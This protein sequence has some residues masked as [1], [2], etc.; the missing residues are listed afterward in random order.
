MSDLVLA[1][2]DVVLDLRDLLADHPEPVY[3]VGG[4]VRDALLRRPIKDV[5]IAAPERAIPLARR[6]ANGGRRVLRPRRRAR[7]GAGAARYA[8]RSAVD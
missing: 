1:W 4:A 3:I 8:R 6:I 5:D 2:S 7:R